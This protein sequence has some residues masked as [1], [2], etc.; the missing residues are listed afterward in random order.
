MR[1]LIEYV[2]D[3]EG[4]TLLDAAFVASSVLWVS[5]SWISSDIG[6]RRDGTD[7]GES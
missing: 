7:S 2:S 4:S 3:S 5:S 6:G 1:R